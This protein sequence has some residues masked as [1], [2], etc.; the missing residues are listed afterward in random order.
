MQRYGKQIGVYG[1]WCM[2]YGVLLTL[3]TA[4]EGTTFRSAVPTYPV[5]ITVNTQ[6]GPFVHFVPEATYDYLTVDRAGYHYHDYTQA[7]SATDMIGYAGVL[8]YIDGSGQYN[9]FDLCCPH[10]LD[11][12]HPVAVDGLYA[13]CPVCGEQYDLSFGLAVPT[14]HK[15][16]EALRR[17]PVVNA[18]GK[19]TITQ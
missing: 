13:V 19:L 8:I 10:C 2:V 16:T 14:Q 7:L 4:C 12:K 18:S 15:S 9:A 6:L 3:L 1:V 11:P 5:R 17:Y